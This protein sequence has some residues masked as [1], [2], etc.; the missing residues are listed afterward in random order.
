[1]SERE[2]EGGK[3]CGNDGQVEKRL[4]IGDDGGDEDKDDHI[5]HTRKRKSYVVRQAENGGKSA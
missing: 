5:D 2:A 1:M 3:T 4:C